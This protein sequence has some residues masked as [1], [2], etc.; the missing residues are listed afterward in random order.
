MVMEPKYLAFRSWWDPLRGLEHFPSET[1][2]RDE[3]KQATEMG[4]KALS[5][6]NEEGIDGLLT[7]WIHRGFFWW[8]KSRANMAF[9]RDW[10]RPFRFPW[11]EGPTLRMEG[12]T[13]LTQHQQRCWL[14]T[15]NGDGRTTAKKDLQKSLRIFFLQ[16]GERRDEPACRVV[17]VIHAG[18]KSNTYTPHTFL[19]DH[20]NIPQPFPTKIT[21]ACSNP[22]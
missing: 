7:M 6:A 4:T 5:K 14:L 21:L 9:G 16:I 22:A 1:S 12:P 19:V 15:P 17:I 20:I 13:Q 8:Y 2:L 3:D 18:K 11:L 10:A